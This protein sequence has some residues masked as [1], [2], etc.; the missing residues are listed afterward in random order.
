MYSS[1]FNNCFSNFLCISTISLSKIC[2]LLLKFV[3]LFNKSKY[4]STTFSNINITDSNNKIL[5][6]NQNFIQ[7]DNN[8]ILKDKYSKTYDNLI[9][10]INYYF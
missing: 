9:K 7:L 2:Y 3:V 4:L 5:F 10:I 1:F 8:I 6:N